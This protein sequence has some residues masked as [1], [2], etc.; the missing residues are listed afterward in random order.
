MGALTAKLIQ[1]TYRSWEPQ[2]VRTL[3]SNEVVPY[4][5]RYEIIKTKQIRVLPTNYWVA[6]NKRYLAEPSAIQNP[7]VT[8]I[9]HTKIKLSYLFKEEK[10]SMFIISNIK[11]YYKIIDNFINIS[12]INLFMIKKHSLPQLSKYNIYDA[13]LSNNLLRYKTNRCTNFDKDIVTNDILLLI[14]PRGESP[15]LAAFLFKWADRFTFTAVSHFASNIIK[16]ELPQHNFTSIKV[17][18]GHLD[19]SNTTVIISRNNKLP[20]ATTVTVLELAPMF[21]HTLSN[22]YMRKYNQG[23]SLYN[24]EHAI[25]SNIARDMYSP[26]LIGMNYNG[27]R[28]EINHSPFENIYPLKK[29]RAKLLD[30][31]NALMMLV[32]IESTKLFSYNSLLNL[33]T[34]FKQSDNNKRLN[35]SRNISISHKQNIIFNKQLSRPYI[36]VIFNMKPCKSVY[37]I[38]K[39]YYSTN[40]DTKV[41]NFYVNY[42]LSVE[43]VLTTIFNYLE[44][45]IV[46]KIDI[47]NIKVYFTTSRENINSLNVS[48]ESYQ[49][50]HCYIAMV[51]NSRTAL[52]KFIDSLDSS[53][54]QQR[55]K[56][57]STNKFLKQLIAVSTQLSYQMEL[58]G[59]D[60]E[61][62]ILSLM[63]V[64]VF[65]KLSERFKYPITSSIDK[66][67]IYITQKVINNINST[68]LHYYVGITLDEL[69]KKYSKKISIQKTKQKS[70]NKH[71]Q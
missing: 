62:T 10:Q 22:S 61:S 31:L 27:A 66:N 44:S 53:K 56:K 23:I 45:L 50:F 69:S 15:S 67:P 35:S 16:E 1:Y 33:T 12:V 39:R 57:S 59:N 40:P 47:T 11:G 30:R 13:I 54:L 21:M 71:E 68:D 29:V 42:L 37:S 46:N 70:K 41:I 60:K 19:L 58:A 64:H 17:L 20:Q 51:N 9:N 24:T 65:Q 34:I 3:D 63:D 55:Y 38:Y 6:D 48:S 4:Q 5:L 2:T 52:T 26:S 18:Q 28:L 25:F 14:N 49:L 43:E 7:S 32:N 8:F 36:S